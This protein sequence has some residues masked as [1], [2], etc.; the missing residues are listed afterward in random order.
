MQYKLWPE[1]MPRF[2][3]AQDFGMGLHFGV[4]LAAQ[5]LEQAVLAEMMHFRRGVKYDASSS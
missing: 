2:G 5:R 4:Y 1:M 3:I